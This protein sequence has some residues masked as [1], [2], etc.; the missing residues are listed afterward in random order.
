M[1]L[2]SCID[3]SCL[4]QMQVKNRPAEQS[5]NNSNH[6]C[7]SQEY[8]GSACKSQLSRLQQCLYAQRNIP[9]QA[10]DPIKI[11]GS[12]DQTTQEGLA[13]ILRTSLNGGLSV[14]DSC[15]VKLE[16]FVCL[17]LFP[18]CD[19]E[20]GGNTLVV[21][22]TSSCML[23]RDELCTEVWKL[24]EQFASDKLPNCEEDLED[25]DTNLIQSCPG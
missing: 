19:D 14:S 8:A 22:S 7:T 3:S 4:F 1:I 20:D 25:S 21:P 11:A 2:I 17:H 13:N 12:V 9:H 6:S 23:V 18:L 15:K 16:P 24:V 10:S 5:L